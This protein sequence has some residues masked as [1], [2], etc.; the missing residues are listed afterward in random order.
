MRSNHKGG[1]RK[2]VKIRQKYSP[3]FQADEAHPLPKGYFDWFM[4]SV[5]GYLLC[6]CTGICAMYYA[7]RVSALRTG[8]NR[9]PYLT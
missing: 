4:C 3:L 2:G 7:I 6:P 9:I 5:L 1:S 8:I